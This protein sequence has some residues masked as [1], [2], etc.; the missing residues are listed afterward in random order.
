MS[1]APWTWSK[2]A[3]L[4]LKQGNEILPSKKWTDFLAGAHLQEFVPHLRAAAKASK[5]PGMSTM[6]AAVICMSSSLGSIE[7]T[8]DSYSYFSSVS[9][10]VSKVSE[11][12][13]SLW[14]ATQIQVKQLIH[15]L[16]L[17]SGCFEHAHSLCCNGAGKRRH[18]VFV[19]APWL[20]AHWHGWRECES[21]VSI[22]LNWTINRKQV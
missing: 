14:P 17:F 12:R 6:K 21:V 13:L 4:Q 15:C 1:W 7:C 10:R 11:D 5:M 19:A 2:W 20:G 8:K 22:V 16:L 18:P 3:S 9:Y